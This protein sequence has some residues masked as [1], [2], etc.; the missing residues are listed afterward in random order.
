MNPAGHEQRVHVRL[1]ADVL[2]PVHGAE[3]YSMGEE[4]HCWH[5][6]HLSANGK[7]VDPLQPWGI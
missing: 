5:G 3:M 7:L 4:P 2:R 6:R 1:S